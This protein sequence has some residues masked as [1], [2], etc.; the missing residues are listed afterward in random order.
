LKYIP[1]TAAAVIVGSANNASKSE[2]AM[3][4]LDGI[5]GDANIINGFRF[6]EVFARV[7]GDIVLYLDKG[8][9]ATSNYLP[10]TLICECKDSSLI[11]D[12]VTQTSQAQWQAK[13]N[14]YVGK[15]ESMPLY[16][17]YDRGIFAISN[18]RDV[19]TLRAESSPKKIDISPNSRLYADIDVGT[20][21]QMLSKGS[22]MASIVGS[23]L[24]MEKIKINT[25][26][27][28]QG[29]VEITF[30]GNTNLYQVFTISK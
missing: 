6:L 16:V 4:P 29:N 2:I 12:I 7:E 14:G 25:A 15:M 23:Q 9:N 13:G 18:S 19:T 24:Q 22:M 28:N 20:L 27:N 3:P 26:G 17:S 10:I 8:Q 1:S 30:N 5:L 21:S 11:G